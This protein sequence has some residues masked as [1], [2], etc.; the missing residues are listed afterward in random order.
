MKAKRMFL[1]LPLVILVMNAAPPVRADER[2]FGGEGVG[3]LSCDRSQERCQM[4]S[5]TSVTI[6]AS[7]DIGTA[8]AICDLHNS[9]CTHDPFTIRAL[10]CWTLELDEA[11]GRVTLYGGLWIHDG[12]WPDTWWWTFKIVDQGPGQVDR[13]GMA[14]TRWN[15]PLSSY[16]PDPDDPACG[17]RDLETLPL[18][19][20][21]FTFYE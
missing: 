16:G 11:N 19:A 8:I 1:M 15:D 2:V 14:K 7:R 12:E 13:M 10:Q 9:I 20:G 3:Y 17:A 21:D 18:I 5:P 6:M 4:S